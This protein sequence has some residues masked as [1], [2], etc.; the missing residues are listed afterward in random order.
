VPIVRAMR[1]FLVV[2]F[3]FGSASA[4]ASQVTERP[5]EVPVVAGTGYDALDVNRLSLVA[6]R[7]SLVLDGQ[8]IVALDHGHVASVDKAGDLVI[9]RLEQLLVKRLATPRVKPE[10]TMFLDRATPY[11]SLIEIVYTARQA[12]VREF[13]LATQTRDGAVAAPLAMP[14]PAQLQASPGLMVSVLKSEVLVWSRS[15]DE[16]TLA[17][18]KATI[19]LHR[20][21]A[22]V[23]L[24]TALTEIASRRWPGERRSAASRMIALQADP[25]VSAQVI[26]NVI[27]AVRATVDGKDLFPDVA[28]SGL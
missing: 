1:A 9:T 10:L 20:P 12:G 25:S 23:E 14:T 21:T 13:Y 11:R 27:G 28:L 26:A 8:P 22:I 6:T 24:T 18:P 16:G 19:S 15:G 2:V 4:E 17:Q 3:V 7:H 5:V